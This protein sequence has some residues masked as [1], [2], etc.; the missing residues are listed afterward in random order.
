MTA[1]VEFLNDIRPLMPMATAMSVIRSGRRTARDFFRE[2]GAYQWDFTNSDYSLTDKVVTFTL[3]DGTEIQN[4]LMVKY[5]ETCNV[6]ASSRKDIALNYTGE[7]Y[8]LDP[9][10]TITLSFIPTLALTGTTR[11]IPAYNAFSIPD[12]LFSRYYEVLLNGVMSDMYAMENSAWFDP[13]KANLRGQQYIEARDAAKIA[14]A[15]DDV[16]KPSKMAYGGIR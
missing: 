14:V 15:G 4:M 1:F 9:P 11:L 10:N 8:Y 7:A 13:N 6:A 16:F 2:T 12:A 5:G 3:P